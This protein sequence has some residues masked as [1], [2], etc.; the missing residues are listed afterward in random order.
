MRPVWKRHNYRHRSLSRRLYFDIDCWYFLFLS[1]R[2]LN[3]FRCV[4]R[5]LFAERRAKFNEER[6]EVHFFRQVSK[7]NWNTK[8]LLRLRVRRYLSN[9]TNLEFIYEFPRNPWIELTIFDIR[10]Y[11]SPVSRSPKNLFRPSLNSYHVLSIKNY[12]RRIEFC[13]NFQFT[14]VPTP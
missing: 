9:P 14:L 3:A 6:H 2:A 7:D 12:L 5:G 8:N 4:F 11:K 1:H 10:F 13:N